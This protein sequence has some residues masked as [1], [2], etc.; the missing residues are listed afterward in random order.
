MNRKP[1]KIKFQN[2]LSFGFAIDEILGEL[3]G[4]FNFIDSN[5]PDFIVFGPYGNDLPPKGNYTRIGYF[6]ENMKPD[7]ESCEWAFGIPRNEA[8]ND[9][10]YQRI[11]WHGL[12]PALLLKPADQDVERILA[13]KTKFCNFLYSHEV[14]YREAFFKQLSKY[15]KV[16]APGRSMNNMPGI[17]DLYKGD[18]WEI[19]K[20]FLSPYKFTIAFENDIFPGY[21]TEKLYDAMMMNSIPVYCGDP[22]IAEI[23][24]TKSFIN[25]LDYL[26]Q[27]NIRLVSWMTK[28][29]QMDFEDMRPAFLKS[30][31]QRLK[32][33]I[34]TYLREYKTHLRFSGMDFTPLIE[35]IIA[36]DKNPDLY[37]S[38]LKQPWFNNN[39]VPQQ[40]STKQRWMQIFNS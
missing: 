14:P 31:R 21:Q 24:N 11:Q 12:D 26:P 39:S 29:G 20:Q 35:Q 16:D 25:A 9:A 38:Y 6:C 30:P 1:I 10:R 28:Q 33:K 13:S 15:K 3:K 32:R 40:T 8:I 34:K 23:F 19:K 17:D 2:G 4:D 37:L 22:F 7:L 5:E 36:L 18:K 27:K